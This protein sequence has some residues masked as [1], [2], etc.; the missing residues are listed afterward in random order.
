VGVQG[1][2]GLG[3]CI[4]AAALDGSRAFTLWAHAT[5]PSAPAYLPPHAL[6][7]LHG[8]HRSRA[9]SGPSTTTCSAAG[10]NAATGVRWMH[11]LPAST[12][13]EVLA[14]GTRLVERALSE[15]PLVLLAQLR[16]LPQLQTPRNGSGSGG[17]GG[18]CT[19]AD[20][21]RVRVC[22]A[23]VKSLSVAWLCVR[24]GSRLRQSACARTCFLSNP[25]AAEFAAALAVS[26]EVSVDDGSA[27][28]L[29][30]AHDAA[31]AWALLGL[32]ETQASRLIAL[33][34]ERGAL[35]FTTAACAGGGS[36]FGLHVRAADGGA[37]SAAEGRELL[38]W[39][40]A[41]RVARP[42]VLLVKRTAASTDA[43]ALASHVRAQKLKLAPPAG[44]GF[45][46]NDGA[47]RH[48]WVD[49]RHTQLLQI[50]VLHAQQDRPATVAYELLAELRAGAPP[51]R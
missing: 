1:G 5:G 38:G 16:A 43:R 40:A 3:V 51:V 49:M 31:V 18:A 27:S 11:R 2:S 17:G 24:C 9:G 50:D 21:C 29:A 15:R 44:G 34:R 42:A 14:V 12:H 41:E 36:Q 47:P 10:A 7:R 8:V 13:V 32:S 23:E 20:V 46:A 45:D 37:L 28:A 19:A 35:E 22:V 4:V 25:V 39:L 33:A 30:K 26:A 6:V 48:V